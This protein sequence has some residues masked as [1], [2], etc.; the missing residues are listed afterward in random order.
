M[1]LFIETVG[2]VGAGAMGSQIAEVFALNGKNVILSDIKDEFVQKGLQRMR[3]SLDGL[4]S[5]HEG[6]AD[7]E[8]QQAESTLG[9]QLTAEQKDAARKRIRPTYTKDRVAQAFGRVKGTTKLEDMSKCEL[10]VEAVLED[11]K[12][13][14]DVF[15]RLNSIL[16]SRAVLATN[17]SSLSVSDLAVTS[18]RPKRFL[19][20]HFFNPPTTLPL[21]EVIP[22]QD[23]DPEAVED[24]VNLVAG[25]RNHRYPMMPVVV[26]DAPGFLVNRILGAML[27]ESYA[28]LEENIASA[29]DID[30]A[31]KAGAG[32]PMGPLE[33][34]DH[35]GLDIIYHAGKVM[36]AAEGTYPFVKKP[37]VL[38]KLVKEG[39]FGKKSGSGF[40]TH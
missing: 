11:K 34:S 33:L 17:T 28:A 15:Q 6:K 23:S 10:V 7:R 13:K 24:I 2:V 4:A 12:V 39:R 3:T 40:F 37:A 16:D 35:I 31:M 26:K 30:K 27:K 29:R 18:G 1:V 25:L 19:G 32:L 38:E 5:F 14:A 8:I 36:E 20:L 9:V 21:V 22:A